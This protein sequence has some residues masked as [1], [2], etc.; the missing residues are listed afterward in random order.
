M[1]YE[2]TDQIHEAQNT[3][4]QRVLVN[5]VTNLRVPNRRNIFDQLSEYWLPKEPLLHEVSQPTT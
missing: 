5:V 2:I 4:H 3:D 1:C